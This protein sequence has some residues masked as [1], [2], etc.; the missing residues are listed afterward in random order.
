[1]TR[2]FILCALLASLAA[3]NGTNPFDEEEATTE[4]TTDADVDETTVPDEDV[5]TDSGDPISSDRTTLPGTANP[6]ADDS[7]FRREATS[8]D[9]GNGYAESVSY[10]G[11]TDTFSVD[12]LAFDGED[13]YTVV[14]DTNGDR[15]GVGPFSVFEAPATAVDG[16]T[17]GDI[18]QL[19]YRALYGVSPD[20]NSSLAIVRTGAFIEYGFGGFVYQREGGV[21]LP[22]SGQA[23]YTG[24]DNYGGLRDFDGQGG[25]EYV[26]GDIEVRIDFDD[27]NEGSG[28][29]G[30]VSNRRVF[31]LNGVDVT[32]DILTAF[33]AGT[34]ELPILRFI[35]EPGVIDS[36]GEIIGTVQST[37]PADGDAFEEGNYYA[38]LSGDNATTITG[39]IVSTADDPRFADVTVRETGGFFAVRE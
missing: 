10:D 8:E 17:S 9:N 7:L 14:R 19:N 38:V 5:T 2:F 23:L 39:I 4:E 18:T 30:V 15:F 11:A 32:N 22:T 24:E 34:T 1:M 26:N 20:G 33:G 16:L 35:I 25:L 37:N 29:I 3:C 27:F 36:N 12:N 6:S 28:V 21:T 31:D 13:P